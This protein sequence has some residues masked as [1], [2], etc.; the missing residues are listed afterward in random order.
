MAIGK[1]WY[2]KAKLNPSQFTL[3][4]TPSPTLLNRDCIHSLW[5]SLAFQL[6]TIEISIYFQNPS[7]SRQLWSPN[8]KMKPSRNHLIASHINQFSWNLIDYNPILIPWTQTLVWI[9]PNPWLITHRR[10]SILGFPKKS[11]RKRKRRK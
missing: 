11:T 8:T 6:F 4:P 10:K 5:S 1:I 2:K 7:P 3:A 9:Q